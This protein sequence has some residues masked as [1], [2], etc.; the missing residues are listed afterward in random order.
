MNTLINALRL[1]ALA[2]LT[3]TAAQAGFLTFSNEASFLSAL[4]ADSYTED[5]I[6]QPNGFFA[7]P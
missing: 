7:S 3:T 1:A 2:A 4:S 6:P 5:F